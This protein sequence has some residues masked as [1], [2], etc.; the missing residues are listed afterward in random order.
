MRLGL[1]PARCV[2][3]ERHDS[4]LNPA[5]AGVT[6]GILINKVMTEEQRKRLVGNISGHLKAARR[7]IRERMLEH[8]ARMDP[9]FEVAVRASMDRLLALTAPSSLAKF[10]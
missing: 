5:L 10:A 4:G 1:Q 7:D 2:H 6:A 8:F 3:S 9:S